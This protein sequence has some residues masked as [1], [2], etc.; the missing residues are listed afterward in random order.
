MYITIGIIIFVAIVYFVGRS[1]IRKDEERLARERAA[2]REARE[3]LDKL[4]TGTPAQR[5]APGADREPAGRS[6][7]A[8]PSAQRVSAISLHRFPQKSA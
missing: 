1:E 5:S 7:G 3:W 2:N 4:G 6:E 8:D